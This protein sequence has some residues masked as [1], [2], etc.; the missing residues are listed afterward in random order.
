MKPPRRWDLGEDPLDK[1]EFDIV[2]NPKGNYVLYEDYVAMVRHLSGLMMSAG[3][4][5]SDQVV[6]FDKARE[7]VH[8]NIIK[9]AAKFKPATSDALTPKTKPKT[10]SMTRKAGGWRKMSTAPLGTPIEVRFKTDGTSF[11]NRT[12]TA[13]LDEHGL[14]IGKVYWARWTAEGK[15]RLDDWRPISK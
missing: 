6:A 12:V 5:S 11:S 1:W 13:T 2:E 7:Q 9:R 15:D 3:F 10:P 4:Q 14:W 8:A